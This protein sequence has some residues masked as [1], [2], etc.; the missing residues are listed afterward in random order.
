EKD[1]AEVGHRAAASWAPR[2]LL[3]ARAG[4]HDSAAAGESSAATAA[5]A[6]TAKIAAAV[7]VTAASHDARGQQGCELLG[8]YGPADADGGVY[9]AHGYSDGRNG[10]ASPRVAGLRTRP[11]HVERGSA[12]DDHQGCQHTPKRRPPGLLGLRRGDYRWSRNMLRRNDL[13]AALV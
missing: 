3:P 13:C 5:A 10:N 12:S 8:R 1:Q 11:I 2:L 6:A 7:H 9:V 4:R